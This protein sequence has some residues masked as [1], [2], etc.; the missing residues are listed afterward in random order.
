VSGLRFEIRV[1]PG[2]R[3]DRVGGSWGPQGALLVRV[4]A[5]AVDGKANEAAL[6]VLA[7]AFGVRRRHVTLVSGASSRTKLVHLD[8][9]RGRG[10]E[11]LRELLTASGT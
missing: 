3:A 4:R 6:G 9:P 1:K 10:G 5:P 11:R 2:A 7:D 8:G